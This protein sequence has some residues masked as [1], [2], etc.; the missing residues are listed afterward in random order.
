M[1]CEEVSDESESGILKAITKKLE[2]GKRLEDWSKRADVTREEIGG[3]EDAADTDELTREYPHQ[4]QTIMSRMHSATVQ[5]NPETGRLTVD[6]VARLTSLLHLQP[7]RSISSST[8]GHC[9]L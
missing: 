2:R 9:S 1:S 6:L 8:N 3:E 5:E 7:G 4:V